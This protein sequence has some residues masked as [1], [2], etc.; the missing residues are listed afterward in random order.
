MLRRWWL[1]N[2][3][4]AQDDFWNSFG[5]PAY[6]ESTVIYGL[7]MPYLTY[8]AV[9]SS[10][11]NVNTVTASLWYRSKSWKDI[12]AKADEIAR[13]IFE[14]PPAVKLD[15]GWYKIR[16]PENL[17]FAQRLSEDADE[18]VRRIVINVEIEFL[19]AC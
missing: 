19:T 12:D 4:Q 2:K 18:D 14:M 10:L 3:W 8:E 6:D 1:M 5:I 15:D 16:I 13:S 7:Q 9:S 17:A 11:G